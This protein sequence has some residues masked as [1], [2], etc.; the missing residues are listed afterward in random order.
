MGIIMGK[1][2]IVSFQG[3]QKYH[4]TLSLEVYRSSAKSWRHQHVQ[5]PKMEGFLNLQKPAISGIAF[6]LHFYR[7]HTAFYRW[8][9]TSISG[10]N[11]M[12][13]DDRGASSC[14][15]KPLKNLDYSQLSHTF[16]SNLTFEMLQ[17][18]S[19][20]NMFERSMANWCLEVW[21]VSA[22]D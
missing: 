17:P 15:L 7:I 21:G 14:L 11:E 3:G 18:T 19:F 12:F 16:I 4:Q 22:V 1:R 8:L 9:Y 10:T 6:P 20:H 5:V 2:Q 13:G